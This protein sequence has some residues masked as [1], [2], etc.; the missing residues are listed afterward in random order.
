M[1]LRGFTIDDFTGGITD[2]YIGGNKTYSQYFDNLTPQTHNRS[3]KTR[4]GSKLHI[5]A[6][7]EEPIDFMINY[8]NDQD[9]LYG[10]DGNLYLSLIHI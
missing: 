3:A 6:P 8:A 2:N 10:S 1:A 4:A 7:T 9:L 5:K